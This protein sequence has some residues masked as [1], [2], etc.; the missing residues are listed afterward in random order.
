MQA[1]KTMALEGFYRIFAASNL[2][3]MLSLGHYHHYNFLNSVSKYKTRIIIKK[4]IKTVNNKNTT[5]K[6][7]S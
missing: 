1:L 7:N 2:A 4:I 3:R 5:R 6:Q